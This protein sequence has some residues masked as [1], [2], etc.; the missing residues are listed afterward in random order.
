MKTNIKAIRG[1]WSA[2]YALDKH[3]ASSTYIGDNQSGYPMFD[4]V[5]TEVGEA[6]YQLKYKN[7]FGQV[8]ALAAALIR[9]V[10]PR[11]GKVEM[12]LPAPASTTRSR[13]P[14]HEVAREFANK[15]GVPF[16]DNIIIKSETASSSNSLKD[17]ATKQEKS[18]ALNGRFVLNRRITNA[19]CWNTLVVDDLFHTGATLEAVCGLLKGY[20]KVSNVYVCALT[21]R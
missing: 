9:H 16:F 2:G 8:D 5:R 21:W 17:M 4:T 7:D 18:E 19:G 10:L 3:T 20:S 6:L 12:V 14:V 15:I 11:L 13:Q 1:N